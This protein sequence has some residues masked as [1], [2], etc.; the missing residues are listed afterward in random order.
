M[1][2]NV[3]RGWTLT[4]AVLF[5]GADDGTRRRVVGDAQNELVASDEAAC[6]WRC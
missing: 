1:E 5:G 6:P 3:K 2:R 4:D